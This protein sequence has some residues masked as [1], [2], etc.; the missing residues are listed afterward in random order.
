VWDFAPCNLVDLMMAAVNTCETSVSYDETTR[1]NI[2]E[3]SN[4]GKQHFAHAC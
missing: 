3:N 1:L 2:P 4:L